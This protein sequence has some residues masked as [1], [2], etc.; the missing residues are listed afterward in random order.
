MAEIEPRG[1]QDDRDIWDNRTNQTT[2]SIQR[3]LNM[4]IENRTAMT[5]GKT[6]WQ[7]GQDNRPGQKGQPGQQGQQG[8]QKQQQQKGQQAQQE[9]QGQRQQEKQGH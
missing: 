4:T 7:M 6:F 8:Q 9:Q 2:R 5:A 3:K 1:H